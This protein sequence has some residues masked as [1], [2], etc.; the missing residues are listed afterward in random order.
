MPYISRDSLIWQLS[1][2]PEDAVI[3]YVASS[4]DGQVVLAATYPH[5]SGGF[6]PNGNPRMS[7]RWYY[8]GHK[9]KWAQRILEVWNE[10]RG[11]G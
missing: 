4:Y 6:D 5:P 2:L 8:L 11:D 9:A 10:R 3:N 1:M 7:A